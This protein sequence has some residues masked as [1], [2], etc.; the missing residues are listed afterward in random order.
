MKLLLLLVVKVNY[1]HVFISPAH[2]SFKNF[3]QFLFSTIKRRG[4]PAGL[5]T[6][7]CQSLNYPKTA[8]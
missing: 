3:Q 1:I 5:V 6:A 2:Y 7:R 4:V 8:K